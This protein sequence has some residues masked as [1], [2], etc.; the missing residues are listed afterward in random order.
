M[1]KVGKRITDPSLISLNSTQK[2]MVQVIVDTNSHRNDDKSKFLVER[3]NKFLRVLWKTE[4][5]NDS[6]M[7]KG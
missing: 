5:Y 6:L 3:A 7:E 2:E 4:K 1:I